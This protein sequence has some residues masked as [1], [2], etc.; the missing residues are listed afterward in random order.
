MVHDEKRCPDHGFVVAEKSGA[1]H[2]HIGAGQRGDHPVLAVDG[3]RARQQLARRLLAQHE[4]AG[5]GLQV[6]GGVALPAL[7]LADPQVPV[8]ARQVC[9]QVGRQRDLVEAMGRQHGHQFRGSV[10]GGYVASS[11]V[12]SAASTDS[13]CDGSD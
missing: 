4:F 10:H 1:R 13:A 6:V 7:E 9:T 12:S 11:S 3:V 5:R 8:E 2:R